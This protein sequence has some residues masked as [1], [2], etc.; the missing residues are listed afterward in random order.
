MKPALLRRLITLG[1]LALAVSACAPTE[2]LHGDLVSNT[3]LKSIH[4]GVSRRA[5]VDA[6]LGTPTAV[7]TFDKNIWYYVGS[8]VKQVAFFRPEPIDRKVIVVTFNDAGTV[9][10]VRELG[11]KDGRSVVPAPGA[12]PTPISRSA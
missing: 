12:T 1:C 9:S 8:Q 7:S 10:K 2:S 6:A 5:D 11:L 4:V 3:E